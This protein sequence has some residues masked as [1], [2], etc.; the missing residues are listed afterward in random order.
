M[1]LM[2]WKLTKN[3]N[4]VIATFLLKI[5]HIWLLK[6]MFQSFVEEGKRKVSVFYVRFVRL[7]AK[8]K[9]S[10]RKPL[11]THPLSST[12]YTKV[13]RIQSSPPNQ[14]KFQNNSGGKIRRDLHIKLVDSYEKMSKWIDKQKISIHLL[15]GGK[16]ITL[17]VGYILFRF[18]D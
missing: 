14:N 2:W 5:F 7:C 4:F 13:S 6:K 15:S 16:T 18:L 11:Y 10:P 9:N 3:T 17:I 1:R 12:T 8:S